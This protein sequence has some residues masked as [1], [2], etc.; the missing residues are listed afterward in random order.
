MAKGSGENQPHICVEA[1][2]VFFTDS[3]L[4][5]NLKSIHRGRENA[6][7][8]RTGNSNSDR[9]AAMLALCTVYTSCL[10]EIGL[11]IVFLS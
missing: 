10:A 4:F 11:S 5:L 6:G 3:W 7:A 9:S 1:V 2:Q 8:E